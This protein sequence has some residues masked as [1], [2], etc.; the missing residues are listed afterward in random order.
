MATPSQILANRANALKSTGPRTS[1]GKDASRRNALKHGLAAE[2]LVLP[3]DEGDAVAER[4]LA[5]GP[6]LGPRDEY[7]CWLVEE[8][9]L[10]SVRVDRCRAVERAQRN[11]QARRASERWDA[12]RREEAEKLGATLRKAP[13]HRARLLRSTVQ[14]CDWMIAPGRAWAMPWRRQAIGMRRSRR[15]RWTCWAPPRNSETPASS[16]TGTGRNW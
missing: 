3:E 2:T 16:S 14:G 7:E 5:W 12:D 15:W 11:R 8:V 1:E 4:M 9:A 6:A 13:A 10:S